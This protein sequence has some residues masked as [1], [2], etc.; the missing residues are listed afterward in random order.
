[1]IHL[2]S[3]SV[4]PIKAPAISCACCGIKLTAGRQYTVVP[5]IGTVGP[6]CEQY[7]M[8]ASIHM[9]AAGLGELLNFGSVTIELAANDLG[10]YTYRGHSVYERL[11]M[12]AERVGLS[13]H[14]RVQGGERGTEAVLTLS[15]TGLKSY[16]GTLRARA[17]V[18]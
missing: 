18:A 11:N 7:I 2:N 14:A 10:G 1:M 15:S 13:L 9:R 4:R 5:G 12:A 3:Q 6:K 17:V 16:F 8:D